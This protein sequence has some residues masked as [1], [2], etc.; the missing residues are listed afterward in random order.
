M[1]FNIEEVPYMAK[2]WKDDLTEQLCRA[3]L[4][5]ESVEEVYDFLEDI[6]TIPEIKTFA[7]RLNVAKLILDGH[8]YIKITKSSG[9]STATISRV[10]KTV[11][12]GKDGFATVLARMER[13]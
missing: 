5:L 1:F 6:A 8:S 7:Q 2:Q 12:Q 10:K 4:T 9:A 13:D 3:F 11:E